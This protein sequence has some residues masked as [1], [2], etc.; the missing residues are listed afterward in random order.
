MFFW[1]GIIP[2]K[3]SSSPFGLDFSLPK[4]TKSFLLCP[5]FTKLREID[6]RDRRELF[7][8]LQALYG[9]A[10]PTICKKA[11]NPL[12]AKT[13]SMLSIT[14]LFIM[15]FLDVL[16]KFIL[17]IFVKGC[18]GRNFYSHRNGGE[19]V[20]VRRSMSLTELDSRAKVFPLHRKIAKFIGNLLNPK[21]I[22]D[23]HCYFFCFSES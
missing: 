16:G 2:L 14:V 11:P 3:K 12:H 22:I 20:S 6:S 9:C 8:I 19:A 5:E 15:W 23:I 1:G 7:N 17:K 4:A 10:M 18:R 21:K 13:L